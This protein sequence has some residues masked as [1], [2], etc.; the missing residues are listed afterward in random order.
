MAVGLV[1][2]AILVIVV[3]QPSAVNKIGGTLLAI[4]IIG[5]F[6]ILFGSHVPFLKE[7]I[8]V[9][10]ERFTSSAEVAETTVVGG[11]LE[12]VLDEFTEPFDYL[13]KVPITG[14]ALGLGTA[15]GARFLVGQG[16]LLLSENEWTRIIAESGPLLG[17]SFI[18]WRVALA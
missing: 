7:G 17:L 3:V 2:L 18:I 6:F 11:L 10:S 4:A 15:G 12:R 1:S 14:Y 16:A 13:F 5:F 9:L 8:D